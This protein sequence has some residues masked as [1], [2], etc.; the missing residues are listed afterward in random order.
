MSE[1][2]WGKWLDPNKTYAA[3]DYRRDPDDGTRSEY[4]DITEIDPVLGKRPILIWMDDLKDRHP[5]C[6]R[7]WEY[8]HTLKEPEFTWYLEMFNSYHDKNALW[9]RVSGEL[10]GFWNYD[11]GKY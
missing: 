4:H 3:I 10:T 2:Y 1:H 11:K 5:K 6:R 9:K 7:W 8:V